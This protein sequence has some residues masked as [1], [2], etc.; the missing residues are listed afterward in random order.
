MDALILVQLSHPDDGVSESIDESLDPVAEV[1]I[2]CEGVL[3]EPSK[4]ATGDERRS[5][6]RLGDM[7][8]ELYER[9][10]QAHLRLTA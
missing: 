1:L 9:L 6:E 7:I 4:Q 5:G 3:S 10:R 2:E 8:P